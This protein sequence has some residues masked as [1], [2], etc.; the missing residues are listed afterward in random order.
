MVC[1]PMECRP[2]LFSINSKSQHFYLN[3]NKLQDKQCARQRNALIINM[4]HTY[5]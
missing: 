4:L 3:I 2:F 1:T 5:D